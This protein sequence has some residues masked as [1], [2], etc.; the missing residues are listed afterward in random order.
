V[1]HNLEMKKL[2]SYLIL[3]IFFTAC[4][5]SV[6]K[7]EYKTPDI[8]Y[9]ELFKAIQTQSVFDDSKTFVDCVP[10]IKPEEILKTY[11]KEKNN[12]GFNLKI[13]VTKHFIIPIQKP[14]NLSNKPS[15]TIENYLLSLFK[16]LK[17][18]P[19]DDGGS[20]IPTRKPYLATG[21]SQSEFNYA[22]S[23]FAMVGLTETP[24]DSTNKH[25]IQNFIQF[26]QDFGHV[27]AGNR[28]YLMSLSNAPY[29]SLML[30]L[31][32]E[33]DP[34]LL[35]KSLPQ[36]TKEY[37]FWMS[38][39]NKEEV[40]NQNESLQKKQLAYKHVVFSEKNNSLNRYFSAINS[41]RPEAY[42]EDLSLASKTKSKNVYQQI[43]ASSEA[44]WVNSNR[45]LANEALPESIHTQDILPIDLNA[46]L[47][48][49]E[50]TLAKGYA[51]KKEKTYADS[52]EN[53]AKIRKANFNKY[54]W[55]EAK[56]FYFD[57]DFVSKKQ[58]NIYSLAAAFA[59]L[60][61]LASDDQANSVAKVIA[62]KILKPGGL[63]S[64]VYSLNSP[65][66]SN[67]GTPELHW[68]TIAALRKHNKTE[69]AATIK[70]RWVKTNI[71][72]YNSKGFLLEKY[73]VVS[74]QSN[75]TIIPKYAEQNELA[76]AG[77]LYKLLKEK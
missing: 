44:G 58:K 24:V 45:W 35:I 37:Q 2:C 63:V 22:K 77:V 46:L 10:K 75:L 41:P 48:Q 69:L 66:T 57:Y 25:M 76:T 55:N 15:V 32:S 16:S 59:L 56:G 52:F 6:S 4:G 67:V 19:K 31:A 39:E 43:I 73:N 71:D 8:I 20:L 70:Q 34:G 38:A 40:K 60:V 33:N 50:K 14:I 53:L 47:Y 74:T 12:K 7:K 54:F 29:L 27:P 18:S 9:G 21:E 3:L 68:V 62:E 17:K 1:L 30:E 28:S 5:D 64:S 11:E 13:F 51:L 72:H 65:E 23:Y 36:L 49:L 26:I 61:G 42:L